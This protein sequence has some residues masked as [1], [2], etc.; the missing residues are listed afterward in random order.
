MT[1]LSKS[2]RYA[3]GVLGI[4]SGIAVAVDAIAPEFGVIVGMLMM[5]ITV[6]RIKD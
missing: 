6:C 2:A 4:A 5:A 1:K 3:L